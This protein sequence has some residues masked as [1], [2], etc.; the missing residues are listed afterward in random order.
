MPLCLQD[1]VDQKEIHTMKKADGILILCMM[2][3]CLVLLI[4][5][6]WHHK[7]ARTAVVRVRSEEVLRIDLSQDGD[8]S[9]DGTNGAV[10]IE[11]RNGKVRVSQENSPH[12]Y[13]SKQGFVG[14]S[15]VPIV[16]LPN[17]TVITIEGADGEE[18][19]VIS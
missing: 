14:S 7:E 1:R 8:Y 18:D 2:V 11:V 17:E 10:N 16:C 5:L 12:H 13:C 4:P 9:V 15:T 6:F 19:T 3:L